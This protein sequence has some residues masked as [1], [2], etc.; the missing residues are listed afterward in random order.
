MCVVYGTFS[1]YK[2]EKLLRICETQRAERLYEISR[3]YKDNVFIRSS[4]VDSA[5]DKFAA[6][7]FYHK[8]CMRSY[9]QIYRKRSKVSM[10]NIVSEE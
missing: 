2:D 3:F 8:N 5:K 10:I 6:D 9:E 4:H 7:I 1:H